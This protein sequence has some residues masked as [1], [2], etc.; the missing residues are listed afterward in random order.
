VLFVDFFQL[1]IY[2]SLHAL[3]SG[4]VLGIRWHSTNLH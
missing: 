4:N 1:H 3:H 2:G